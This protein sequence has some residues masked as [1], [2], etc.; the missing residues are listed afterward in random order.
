[1]PA[2]S[3]TRLNAALEGWELLPMMPPPLSSAGGGTG[4]TPHT[5]PLLKRRF[6]KKTLVALPLD[7]KHV[8]I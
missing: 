7:K 4:A 3:V 6:L 5:S 1:M 8:L 2:E